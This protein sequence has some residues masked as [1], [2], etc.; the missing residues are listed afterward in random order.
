MRLGFGVYAAWLGV[1]PC[2]N[3]Y[4]CPPPRLPWYGLDRSADDSPPLC[5][6]MP[7]AS[8]ENALVLYSTGLCILKAVG[9]IPCS[10]KK[11]EAPL[12]L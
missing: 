12:I 1:K 2:G 6:T 4:V 3:T 5:S 8:I 9:F 10:L 7:R 11:L